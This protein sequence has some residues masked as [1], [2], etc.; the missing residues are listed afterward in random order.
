MFRDSPVLP[1]AEAGRY[2]DDTVLDL[3]EAREPNLNLVDKNHAP[4]NFSI[5]PTFVALV[6]SFS[7]WKLVNLAINLISFGGNMKSN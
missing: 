6:Q 5:S 7:N 2:L 4:K 3:S 1:K